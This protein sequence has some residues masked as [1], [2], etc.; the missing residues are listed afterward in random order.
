MAGFCAFEVEQRSR[1]FTLYAL[2]S[3]QCGAGRNLLNAVKVRASRIVADSV[4]ADAQAWW[5]R[6]GFTQFALS[7]E[8][9]T[10]GHFEWWR[11][12]ESAFEELPYDPLWEQTTFERHIRE[13]Q[14][15]RR[16]DKVMQRMVKP[17]T[18]PLVL[19]PVAFV[20]AVREAV[21]SGQLTSQAAAILQ[22]YLKEAEQLQSEPLRRLAVWYGE[23][24]VYLATLNAAPELIVAV[25]DLMN[26]AL[27]SMERNGELEG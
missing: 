9:G 14:D 17:N 10:V 2:E 8:E 23:T 15:Q 13:V 21:M 20:D 3:H 22:P 1:E 11:E 26:D 27:L 12:D 18:L 16:V 25:N 5:E 4:L 7:N 6:R 24:L 19:V